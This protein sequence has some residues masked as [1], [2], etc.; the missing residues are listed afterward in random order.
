MSPDKVKFSQLRSNDNNR[1]VQMIVSK[2]EVLGGSYLNSKTAFSGTLDI[3]PN[4]SRLIKKFLLKRSNKLSY[5][6]D[7]YLS[8]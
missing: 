2:P 1:D 4:A 8:G 7:L 5:A 6:K 3:I